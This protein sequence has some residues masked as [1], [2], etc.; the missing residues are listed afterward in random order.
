MTSPDR[1]VA[2][3][4]LTFGVANA[5]SCGHLGALTKDSQGR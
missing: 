5:E 1:Q 2:G 3:T 4:S